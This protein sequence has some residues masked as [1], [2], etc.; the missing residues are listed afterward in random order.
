MQHLSH[1]ER[2]FGEAPKIDV[3]C[4]VDVVAEVF[5]LSAEIKPQQFPQFLT[6]LDAGNTVFH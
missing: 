6:H 3:S 4:L 2:V 1:F 5:S